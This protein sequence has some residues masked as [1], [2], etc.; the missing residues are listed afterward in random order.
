MLLYH[1]RFWNAK[2][3]VPNKWFYYFCL[4]IQRQMCQISDLL[5]L[6]IW[7]HLTKPAKDSGFLGFPGC[8]A[9]PGASPRWAHT[10]LRCPGACSAPSV[11]KTVPTHGSNDFPRFPVRFPGRDRA[12]RVSRFA[13]PSLCR[14]PQNP[15]EGSTAEPSKTFLQAKRFAR[16]GMDS[17]R[18]HWFSMNL[19]QF[20]F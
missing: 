3:D 1:F 17:I 5:L 9:P 20:Q 8:G 12:S 15:L 2:A 10:P 11:D 13:L 18:F 6:C 14:A 16:F 19:T 4:G 7:P